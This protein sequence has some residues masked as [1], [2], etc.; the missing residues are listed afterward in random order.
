M[1]QTCVMSAL[2]FPGF[3]GVD[4][5]L[6]AMRPPSCWKNRKSILPIGTVGIGGTVR[7]NQ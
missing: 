6:F 2:A 4:R 3:A 5:R 7:G 1:K